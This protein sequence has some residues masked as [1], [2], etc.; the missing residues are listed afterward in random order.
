MNFVTRMFRRRRASA[1]D[2][3][4]ARALARGGMAWQLGV[5]RQHGVGC[6]G[7]LSTDVLETIAAGSAPLP[8]TAKTEP[9]RGTACRGAL[10]R[11]PASRQCQRQMKGTCSG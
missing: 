5:L 3:L 2:E 1:L 8:E 9:S 11:D 7:V 10:P 4:R 6:F